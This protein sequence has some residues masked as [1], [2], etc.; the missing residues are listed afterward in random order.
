MTAA[1]GPGE[2]VP[3]PATEDRTGASVS[4][5]APRSSPI[6]AHAGEHL[7]FIGTSGPLPLGFVRQVGV[8]YLV[9]RDRS[10]AWPVDAL[11]KGRATVRLDGEERS[12]TVDLIVD[13]AEK[14]RVLSLF[15]AKYGPDRFAR[16]YASPARVLAVTLADLPPASTPEAGYRHWLEAEFD[17]VADDYDRHITGN[18]M[19]RLLRE[20][21]LATLRSTFE[22]SRHLLEIGCGSG[23]ETLPL[24][25]EGHEI[26]AVD[27]SERM[28][29]VVRAK[30]RRE[31]VSER[32]RTV[33]GT[34]G[35]LAS[36]LPEFGA[37]SFDGAYSTYGAMNCEEDLGSVPQPLHALLG[38]RRRFL[39]GVYNRWCA[40]EVI[41]YALAGQGHRA[42]GRLGRPIRV[43]SSRFCVDV[44]AYSAHEFAGI[45]R[46]WFVPVRWQAAPF[47]LPPS[48]LTTYAEKFSRKFDRLARWDAALARYPPFR[49]LGD[50]FL[51]VLERTGPGAT[52]AHEPSAPSGPG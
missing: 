48:D 22:R 46:P 3:P 16:W 18:R 39:A 44:Y 1:L 19:N 23:M 40:V 2:S 37:G 51:M 36:L 6:D 14:R 27:L 20:R 30:A 9:A 4:P 41:G 33:H 8:V 17:N 34:A 32:L 28:L 12:G 5:P 43:G 26:V 7:F 35:G 10:A 49:S 21:S 52:P 31:G 13:P 29:E 45:F 38:D 47:A 25:Q 50:H 24:L 15:E 11:R 42:L